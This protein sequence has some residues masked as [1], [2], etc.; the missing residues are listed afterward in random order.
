MGKLTIVS[1]CLT[2]ITRF[3]HIWGT[4]DFN[5]VDVCP[6]FFRLPT[7][8]SEKKKRAMVDPLTDGFVQA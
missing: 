6:I 7:A 8:L 2:E 4:V 3:V 1:V 5:N